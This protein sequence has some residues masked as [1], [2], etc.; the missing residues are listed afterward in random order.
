MNGPLLAGVGDRVSSIRLD[1]VHNIVLNLVHG[2]VREQDDR[3]V[4][5]AR[6]HALSKDGERPEP[7]VD[8]AIFPDNVVELVLADWLRRN[9]YKSLTEFVEPTVRKASVASHL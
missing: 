6:H 2:H 7:S 3:R 8:V 4:H 5:P 9:S 1:V